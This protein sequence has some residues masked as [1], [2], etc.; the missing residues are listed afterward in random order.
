M[1]SQAPWLGN[2]L[3]NEMFIKQNSVAADVVKKLGQT[4]AVLCLECGKMALQA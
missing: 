3:S 2:G 4:E 1:E